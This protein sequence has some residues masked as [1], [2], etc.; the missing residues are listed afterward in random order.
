MKFILLLLAL[1]VLACM[2]YGI[3]AGVAAIARGIARLGEG[4]SEPMVQPSSTNIATP[5]SLH[6]DYVP[7]LQALF[8]LHHSGA[9]T[10]GE[11]ER[12]KQRLFAEIN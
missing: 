7:E 2:L 1:F 11:F 3:Y 8:T 10:A 4:P 12:L 9:L 6:R 5:V